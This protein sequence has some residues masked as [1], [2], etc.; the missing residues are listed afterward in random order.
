MPHLLS[1]NLLTSNTNSFILARILAYIDICVSPFDNLY[2]CVVV[3]IQNR[4]GGPVT[5]K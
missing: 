5:V 4:K 2:F 1:V 3:A